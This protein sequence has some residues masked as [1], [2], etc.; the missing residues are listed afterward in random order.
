ME[1]RRISIMTIAAMAAFLFILASYCFSECKVY[2]AEIHTIDSTDVSISEDDQL[3]MSVSNYSAVWTGIDG[4]VK[5]GTGGCKILC[6][7]VVSENEAWSVK[8]FLD[9]RFSGAGEINGRKIDVNLHISSMEVTKREDGS[10]TGKD[11]G[12]VGVC[13]FRSSDGRLEIGSSTSDGYGYKAGKTIEYTVSVTYHD[14]GEIVSIPFFQVIRDVDHKSGCGN[15]GWEA[16][17]G[18]S[19]IYHKYRDN[20]LAFSGNRISASENNDDFEGDD[21]LLKAGIYAPIKSG[22]FSGIFYEGDSSTALELYNQYAMMAAPVKKSNGEG[23]AGAGEEITYSIE[24]NIGCYYKD[25]MEVYPELTITDVLPPELEYVS[26]EITGS[27]SGNLKDNCSI[28]YDETGKTVSCSF[29]DRWLDDTANYNGEKITLNIVCRVVS[30]IKAGTVIS[31]TASID[32][33]IGAAYKSNKVSDTVKIPYRVEYE[34]VSGTEWRELPYYVY[35]KGG[36]YEIK[37][38]KK[39]YTGDVVKRQDDYPNGTVHNIYEGSGKR[40]VWTLKWDADE[41]TVKDGD[42]KFTGTWTYKSNPNVI[43]VNKISEQELNE[44]MEYG[45]P[46]T[47]FSIT[48]V[49]TG[50]TWYR[51]AAVDERILKELNKNENSKYY[52]MYTSCCYYRED[53]YIVIQCEAVHGSEDDYIVKEI[54]KLRDKSVCTDGKYY[55]EEGNAKISGVVGKSEVT[56]PLRVSEF[57]KSDPGYGSE[58]AVV[59]FT[60]T[61]VRWDKFS[62]SDSILNTLVPLM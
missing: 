1:R 3:E 26:A 60:D 11:D 25:T 15:E 43:V 28:T 16:V 56:I 29:Y 13:I 48:S 45:Y 22:S 23:T 4:K 27:K 42:I 61:K 46:G 40:G 47:V 19:G 34:Y 38:E 58:D 2:A 35:C 31:N 52:D 32:H 62:H 39:Y 44:C 53:G 21:E 50:R 59:Y 10:S 41:K 51:L 12:Y 37:D 57:K 54:Q 20:K 9:I 55:K 8:D 33:G 6:V 18:Y 14:T 7:P 17:K 49:E 5:T 36:I 30:D 24:Q